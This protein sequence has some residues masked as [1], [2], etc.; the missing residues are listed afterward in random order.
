MLTHIAQFYEDDE[1][2]CSLQVSFLD[3]ALRA[4]DTALVLA[5]PEHRDVLQ[6]ALAR[7]QQPDAVHGHCAMLDA[8]Q[9]LSRFMVD[10]GVDERRFGA[11]MSALLAEHVPQHARRIW[12]SAEMV[13]MLVDEG[14]PEQAMRLERFWADLV[15]ANRRYAFSTVCSYPHHTLERDGYRR[16]I[17]VICRA[18][19]GVCLPR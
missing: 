10:G 15:R 7:L 19:L 8:G 6:R 18:H 11:A 13:G 14:K 16:W 9:T 4:G 1:S 17:P 5:T 12:V 3:A 2:Y